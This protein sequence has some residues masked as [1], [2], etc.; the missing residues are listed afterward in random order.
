MCAYVHEQMYEVR[1]GCQLSY[2]DSVTFGYCGSKSQFF[3]L[4]PFP[5]P[6]ARIG[7]AFPHGHL[8]GLVLATVWLCLLVSQ[9]AYKVPKVRSGSAVLL[10]GYPLEAIWAQ[11]VVKVMPHS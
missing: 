5:A 1:D 10:G 6:S 11:Q 4:G 2:P 3:L 9:H 8:K 7:P